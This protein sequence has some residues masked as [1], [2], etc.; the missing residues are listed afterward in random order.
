MARGSTTRHAQ[1][2]GDLRF[3]VQLMLK[4]RG[5]SRSSAILGS[6]SLQSNNRK[7]NSPWVTPLIHVRDLMST[8]YCRYLRLPQ[9]TPAL[10]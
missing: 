4:H 1:T 2:A 9:P 6:D 10:M 7:D 8:H 5:I 3:A